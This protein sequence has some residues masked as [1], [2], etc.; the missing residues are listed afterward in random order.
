MSANADKPSRVDIGFAGGQV[1]V[2]RIAPGPYESLRRAL[3]DDRAQRWHELET[4]DST[5]TVD[6]SQIVYV[7]LDTEQ[8]RVGF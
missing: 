3:E 5:V 7:R 2:L 6:L 4:E 1:L 8:H